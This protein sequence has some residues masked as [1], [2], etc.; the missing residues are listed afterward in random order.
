[1][2]VAQ[3]YAHR[4]ARSPEVAMRFTKRGLNQW[5]KAAG[6]VSQDYSFALEALSFFSGEKK[7]APHT[8]WPPRKVP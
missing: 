4:F 3:D 7:G 1:M 2:K 8:D 5:Y 6:L